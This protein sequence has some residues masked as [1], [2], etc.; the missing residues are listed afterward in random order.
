MNRSLFAASLLALT[1]AG[2]VSVSSQ[3][4]KDTSGTPLPGVSPIYIYVSAGQDQMGLPVTTNTTLTVPV[5]AT[6]AEICVETANVRYRDNGSAS[7]STLGIP[8]AYSS[9]GNCFPYSGPLASMSFSAISGSPTLDVSYYK[10][11]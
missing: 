9:P 7:S 6:L 10:A 11:Q 3:S 2:V 1:V 5:G 8:V 4:H